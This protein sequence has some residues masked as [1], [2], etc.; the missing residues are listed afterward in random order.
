MG[1]SEQSAAALRRLIIGYRLSQAL[2]VAAKLG[3]ADL[4]KDGPRSVDDLAQVT[5]SHAPSLYRV[6]RLLAGEGVFAEQDERRFRLT[7][8]AMHLQGDSPRSLRA[9]AVFDGA[10]SNWGAWGNLLHSVNT[11]EAAFDHTF[12]M[13]LFDHL[14]QNAAAAASFDELMATQTMPWAHALV[15]AY[16]F[17]EI[18]TLVDV[19]GG[20]GA[21]LAAI[22]AAHPSMR[23]ILYDLSHVI[24]GAR[25]NLEA[26]GV[27]E[28]CDTIVGNF[29]E[30]IPA[31][32]QGYILKHVLHDWDDDHCDAILRNCRRAMPED[33]R[34]LVV[35]ILIPP[36]NEP[37]YG[38]FLDVNML[39]ITRGRERTKEEYRELFES[40]G[41]TLSRV[42]S[43]Q[44]E[45][46]LIEGLPV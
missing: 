21:L 24:A 2:F 7:P 9:R 27:V 3:I 42:V 4:L 30:T 44:S 32:G 10:Q 37:D 22:L 18:Q 43:T 12:G 33:G 6:L 20:Y 45:L 17:S 26:A 15:D 11:G 14:K 1:D 13:G 35:E 36:G 5:G 8:L 31:G 23:G 38:K 25:P 34:L 16:D 40:T 28:R 19:G 46:S 41:F 29:F 39:V